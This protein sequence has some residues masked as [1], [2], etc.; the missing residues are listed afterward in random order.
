MT[1]APWRKFIINRRWWVLGYIIAPARAVC[2]FNANRGHG[3]RRGKARRIG[4]CLLRPGPRV[5]A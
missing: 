1:V 2:M 4:A 3:A 5:L